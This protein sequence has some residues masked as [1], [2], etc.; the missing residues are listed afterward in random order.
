MENLTSIENEQALLGALMVNNNLYSRVAGV[1]RP[2]M[3]CSSSHG[4][5][6]GAITSFILAGKSATAVTL[7][8]FFEDDDGLKDVGGAQYL[9]SLEVNVVALSAVRDYAECVVDLWKRRC[10]VLLADDL[11]AAAKSMDYEKTADKIG[12][13]IS[14]K[15]NSTIAGRSTRHSA[16]SLINQYINQ[17]NSSVTSTGF[18]RLDAAMAGGLYA[19]KFYAFAARMKAGKTSLM[20]SIA[21]NAAK[22]GAKILYLALEMGG[23]E[24][25]QRILARHI[26][27]NA[28]HLMRKEIS[29]DRVVKAHSDFESIKLVFDNCPLSTVDDICA[30]IIAAEGKF[31]GI[32]IDYIQLIGGANKGEGDAQFQGRVA[33]TIAATVKNCPS[34]WVLTA[35]QLNREGEVRG[36]DGLRMACD[37]LIKLETDESDEGDKCAWLDVEATRYT[38]AVS[39][40]CESSPSLVLDRHIGPYYREI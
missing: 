16:S 25:M 15:I 38:A 1:L 40:G 37:M 30:A 21:Y 39:I 31:D 4:A 10:L 20:A 2:E 5:I 32:I 18:R 8:P 13:D 26:G 24:I 19:G 23:A 27:C 12:A 35:A 28:N 17:G 14:A 6:Y 7:K 29:P 3:F 22:S 11:S 36:S 33:Q 34:I 9:V